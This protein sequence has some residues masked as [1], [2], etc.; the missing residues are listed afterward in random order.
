MIQ[1]FSL[2]FH[3]FLITLL[4]LIGLLVKYILFV[5]HY[6][7]LKIENSRE[8]I[9]SPIAKSFYNE[10]IYFYFKVMPTFFLNINKE[11]IITLSTIQSIYWDL[12]ILIRIIFA[13]LYTTFIIYCIIAV[14]SFIYYTVLLH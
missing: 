2:L 12:P 3:L 14:L 6:I 4:Y 10:I 1:L 11:W 7:Y 5:L 13:I 8:E 9:T